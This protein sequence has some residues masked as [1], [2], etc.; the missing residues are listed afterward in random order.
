MFL[1]LGIGL[2]VLDGLDPM[3][4]GIPNLLYI[5]IYI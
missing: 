3:C 2:C 5:Y 4:V 1:V